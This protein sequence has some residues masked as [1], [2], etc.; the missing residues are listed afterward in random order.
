MSL[1]VDFYLPLLYLERKDCV[2]PGVVIYRLSSLWDHS[3]RVTCIIV[4]MFM[5]VLST[6]IYSMKRLVDDFPDRIF[7]IPGFPECLYMFPDAR[8]SYLV[9]E[10]AVL[11]VW[12]IFNL[13]I[14]ATS[15]F[16]NPYMCTADVY[17]RFKRDGGRY[18]LC[19]FAIRFTLL[20]MSTFGMD[21]RL[22]IVPVASALSVIINARIFQRISLGLTPLHDVP[23]NGA[24]PFYGAQE[25][26][27]I[28]YHD[29]FAP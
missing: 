7:V 8:S 10:S 24:S 29:A 16:A 17:K 28:S 14:F 12:D 23:K 2:V 3:R 5:F 26:A 19:L 13:V 18:F 11:V 9:L 4:L 22:S 27:V 25:Y 15:S 20:F 21:S 6:M 1:R